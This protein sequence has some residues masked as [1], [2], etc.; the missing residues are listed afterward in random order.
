MTFSSSVGQG[1]MKY[2]IKAAGDHKRKYPKQI[3]SMAHQES[4]SDVWVN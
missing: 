4:Y 2:W 1:D 3:E